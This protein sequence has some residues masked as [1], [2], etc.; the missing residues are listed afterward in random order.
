[1]HDGKPK[2]SGDER[3]YAGSTSLSFEVGGAVTAS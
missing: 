3:V 2:A 1:M